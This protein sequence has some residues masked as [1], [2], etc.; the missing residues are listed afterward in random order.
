MKGTSDTEV[1][2]EQCKPETLQKQQKN[3]GKLQGVYC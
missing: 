3:N 2:G 1:H